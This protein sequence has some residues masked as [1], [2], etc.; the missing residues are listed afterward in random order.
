MSD[1]VFLIQKNDGRFTLREWGKP[2]NSF[3]MKDWEITRFPAKDY[4]EAQKNY[5][6]SCLIQYNYNSQD[7]AY[8][9]T[10]LY[11]E[12]E[13]KAEERYSKLVRKEFKTYLTDETDAF[14][15]GT[16]LS[17]RF[18][19]L[20]E[21]I[22]VGVGHD[23]SEINLLDTVGL[24]ININGRVFSKYS[25]WV[26]KEI[27]P[28]QDILTLENKEI[29]LVNLLQNPSFETDD[30]WAGLNRATDQKLFGNYSS[31]FPNGVTRV[32]TQSIPA[33]IL[34]HKYYGRLYIKSAGPVNSLDSRFEMHY[35]DIP[36]GL[37]VFT[38]KNGN[39]PDW[40]M[41]SNIQAVSSLA[42]TTYWAVRNFQVNPQADSWCDGLMIIDLTAAFGEG[43]EPD[44]EF[45]DTIPF[46]SGTYKMFK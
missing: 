10:L 23:T 43:F 17:G 5:L 20:R 2:Y 13:D 30:I 41:I 34:N 22:Q 36:G 32:M 44:R 31:Y 7:K 15:L 39:Y 28:A 40:T 3:N 37:F 21:T 35:S 46:F 42:S 24:E 33:P 18:S 45:M 25:A 16:K 9:S 29:A 12:D 1:M 26:V 14:S 38:S 19:T 4:S 6:S 27:D 8:D 11:N